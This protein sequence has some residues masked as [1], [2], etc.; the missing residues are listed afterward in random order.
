[1]NS[2]LTLFDFQSE[3]ERMRLNKTLQL[4]FSLYFC[5]GGS[6]TGRGCA[7]NPCQRESNATGEASFSAAGTLYSGVGAAK[8]KPKISIQAPVVTKLNTS[9]ELR[10]CNEKNVRIFFKV[11]TRKRFFF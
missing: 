1:M 4:H 8:L 2:S 7:L 3:I 10:V 5:V 9:Q 11:S 6:E